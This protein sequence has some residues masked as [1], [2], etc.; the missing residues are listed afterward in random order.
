MLQPFHS[1]N[2]MAHRNSC[3]HRDRTHPP[4]PSCLSRREFI[5]SVA[6][7]GAM[8]T[9]FGQSRD[10]GAAAGSSPRVIDVHH[11]LLPPKYIAA[12]RA[13]ILRVASGNTEILKWTAARSLEDMDRNGV[14]TAIVSVSTPGIWFG[15]PE[16]ARGLAR[17]INEFAARMKS[18]HPGRFGL[19]AALPLPDT[20]ASLKE[21]EYALDT[22]H[23]DGIGLV[24][25]YE[26]KYLGDPA[27][28]PVFDELQR[29]KAVV[30]CHPTPTSCCWT[31]VPGIPASTVEFGF[32]TTRAIMSLLYSGT[33]S[34]CP[35]VKF[36]FSHGGGTLP[37]LA[38]RMGGGARRLSN[39]V[40]HGP[41]YEFRKLHFDTASVTNPPAMAAILKLVPATQVMFGTDYPWGNAQSAIEGLHSVGL[42]DQELE[43][44]R[45]GSATRLFPRLKA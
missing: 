33:L 3:V 25:N 40:P 16:E 2:E 27:F 12:K 15:N 38:G 30:Y 43:A 29:R 28:A 44:I 14:R 11:H 10:P 1:R 24:S 31:L 4:T 39:L 37:F 23:A 22:L 19:F 34:R 20:D 32:D 6:A 8:R 9:A 7:I 26:D 17:E 18:D 41:E 13:E 36:V 45:H 21:I 5:A 42:S 35:D